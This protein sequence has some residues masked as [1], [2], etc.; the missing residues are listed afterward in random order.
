MEKVRGLPKTSS[1]V[2]MFM[3][4]VIGSAVEVNIDKQGRV[5]V[6]AAL[7]Q[8]SGIKGELVIV[9]QIDRIEVWDKDLWDTAVDK[10]EQDLEACEQELGNLGL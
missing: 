6:P 2:K 3:R 1:A 7:R 5:L 8:D 4:K 9:G 10:D